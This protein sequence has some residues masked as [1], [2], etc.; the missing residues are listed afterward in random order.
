VTLGVLGGLGPAASCRFYALLVQRRS[1]A[2]DQ[3]HPDVILYSKASV[4]DRSAWLVNGEAAENPLPALL[5]GL[6]LLERTGASAIAVP[7]ATAHHFYREMQDAVSVPVLNM[8]ACTAQALRREGVTKA[9]LLATEGSYISGAFGR[10]L[11]NEGIEALV[12]GQEGMAALTELIYDIKAGSMPPAASLEAIAA[13]LLEQGAQRVILGCTELSLLEHL[14]MPTC[15]PM[16]FLAEELLGSAPAGN[17]AY[18][19]PPPRPS[20]HP[21]TGGERGLQPKNQF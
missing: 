20:G 18:G 3:D 2:R 17:V 5:E 7:C 15:D 21:S 14:R 9:A 11:E 16:E 4:P 6:A 8:L 19:E 12:P 13:P 1:A 10:A